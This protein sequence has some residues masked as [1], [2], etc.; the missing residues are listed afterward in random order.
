MSICE[1]PGENVTYVA[2]QSSC[3]EAKETS[4][5]EIMHFVIFGVLESSM[6]LLNYAITFFQSLIRNVILSFSETHQ[7]A[8]KEC[9][10]FF[11][12]RLLPFVFFT[13][14]NF[15]LRL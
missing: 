10:A 11:E 2:I 3:Q 4:Y 5:D 13:P 12:G 1:T 15:K 8:S 6:S 7:T 14:V 9:W